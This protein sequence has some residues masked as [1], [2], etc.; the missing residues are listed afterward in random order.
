[1]RAWDRDPEAQRFFEYPPLPPPEEHLRRI[2]W[3]I[4]RWTR[5]YVR[6]ETIPFIVE[7]AT[8]AVAGSVKLHDVLGTNAQISYMTIAETR[9]RHGDRGRQALVLEGP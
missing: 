8:G 5:E 1:M 2:W 7:D 6:G 4:G 3:V 9:T